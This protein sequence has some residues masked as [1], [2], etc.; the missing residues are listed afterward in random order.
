MDESTPTCNK[1][2]AAVGI[3]QT[4]EARRAYRE[5][6]VTTPGLAECIS[7]AILYDETIRQETRTTARR[8][9]E[10]STDA[11]IIPGIKVDTGAKDLAGHPGREGHR[12]P[13][14]A[15]RPP[16]GVRADG[17]ALCQ[18]ARRDRPSATAFPAGA[19]SRPTRRR[20][21]ATPRCARR[22]AW[23]R[24]SSPKCSWT[25]STRWTRCARGHRGS[26]A[27]GL[28]PAVRP[29]GGAGGHDAQAQHGASGVGLPQ[30]GTGGRG[31][32]RHRDV[33]PA[34]RAG[35][36][37]RDRVPVGRPIRRAGLRPPER[38]ELAIPKARCPGRWRSRSPAPSSNRPWRSGEA[39]TP[40]WR[41]HSKRWRIG[42]GATGPR[43]AASTTPRWSRHE[44]GPQATLSWINH[45]SIPC[46][47]NR[48]TSTGL[49]GGRRLGDLLAAPLPGDGPIGEAWLLSDRADHASR[50]ADGPLKGRTL[51]QVLEQVPATSAGHAGRA[52]PPLPPAAE[53]PRRARAALAPGASRG[54]A[55]TCYQLARAGRPKH[56]SCWRRG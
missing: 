11:G 31:G 16:G 33:P 5:L 6:I 27:D 22:P 34:G 54:R 53:V 2:F 46:G 32:R 10:S 13:G 42:P 30:A 52:V 35:C 15:A 43:A 29:R 9:S 50:V 23:S 4:E 19:A 20:W 38:D 51:G 45:A 40:T 49:W 1:R 24:S 26:P 21:P 28:R 41:R 47:S 36:R 8:S 37:S 17:R 55:R 56:G 14:R 44:P 25:A 48:S 18:V 7:G 39:R 12:G 3:P